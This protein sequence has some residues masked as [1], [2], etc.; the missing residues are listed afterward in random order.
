MVPQRFQIR[1]TLSHS[2]FEKE[3]IVKMF[4]R[5]IQQAAVP[6]LLID[7][8]DY[9]HVPDGRCFACRPRS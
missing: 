9:L 7:V 4:H 1:A 6:G 5:W 3:S 8:A 2:A